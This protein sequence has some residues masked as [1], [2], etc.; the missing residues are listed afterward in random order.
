M[1][2]GA[3]CVPTVSDVPEPGLLPQT[4]DSVDEGT[5]VAQPPPARLTELVHGGGSA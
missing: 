3:Y 5:R 1:L 2:K 4:A